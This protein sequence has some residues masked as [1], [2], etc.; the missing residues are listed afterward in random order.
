MSEYNGNWPAGATF[1]KGYSRV[2]KQMKREE[3]ERRNSKTKPERRRSA[4]SAA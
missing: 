3:A 2:L 4:R 1:G